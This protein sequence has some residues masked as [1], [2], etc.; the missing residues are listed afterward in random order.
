MNNRTRS[1]RLGLVP[2][3][4]F[5][6]AA[7]A[8]TPPL[9]SQ[10]LGSAEN[11]VVLG[12][13]TVTNTGASHFDS[14][15]GVSPGSAITGFPPGIITNGASHAADGVATQADADFAIAYNDFA[16]LASPPANN[17]SG[18]DLGGKTLTPGVY[19]YDTSATSNG[20]LIF[21]AQNDPSARFVIQIGTTLITSSNSSVLLING[22]DARN[23]YFQVGPR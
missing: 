18:T 13:S 7:L 5:T 17:L 22:A 8:F 21:D 3:L 1:L 12:A 23:V 9:K 4:L 14:S 6:L 16:G 2:G 10:S 15:V 19:H 11:F 20:L